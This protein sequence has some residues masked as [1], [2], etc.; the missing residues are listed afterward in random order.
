MD[1]GYFSCHIFVDDGPVYILFTD[2]SANFIGHGSL[3]AH[4]NIVEKNDDAN[5]ESLDSEF[6]DSNGTAHEDN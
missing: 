2:L 5:G 1:Y 4:G 3:V 6:D